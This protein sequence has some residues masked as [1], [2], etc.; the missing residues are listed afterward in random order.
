MDAADGRNAYNLTQ[1]PAYDVSPAWSSDAQQIAFA[2]FRDENWEVYAM[3]SD[4]C[5]V[6]RL[7]NDEGWDGL[8]QWQPDRERSVAVDPSSRID[9]TA[10]PPTA[11]VNTPSANLRDGAGENFAVIATAA[12]RECLTISGRSADGLWLQIEYG[13]ATAWVSSSIVE[14]VGDIGSVLTIEP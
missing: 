2:S 7:T 8:P 1:N 13:D 11:I 9:A 3:S 6:R 14:I 5:N 10:R 4:G 12:Q